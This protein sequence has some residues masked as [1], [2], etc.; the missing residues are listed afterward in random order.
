MTSNSV[1]S[2]HSPINLSFRKWPCLS[3]QIFHKRITGRRSAGE[4]QKPLLLPRAT[5]AR[6]MTQVMEELSPKSKETK[7]KVLCHL[8]LEWRH[9]LSCR[10]SIKGHPGNMYPVLS[11][12]H[13]LGTSFRKY[14]VKSSPFS[15]PPFPSSTLEDY[16]GKLPL[17]YCLTL[18]E[19]IASIINKSLW[20]L[21]LF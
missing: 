18:L 3:Q 9:S 20:H 11:S 13:L 7:V 6:K 12:S 1:W 5:I 16:H 21:L 14:Q 2:S 4:G 15:L 10:N 19:G 17:L 8:R